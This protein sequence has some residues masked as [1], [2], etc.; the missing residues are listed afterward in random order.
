[1]EEGI[2]KTL[3]TI[4]EL[5]KLR[6]EGLISQDIF[7]EKEKTEK[8]KLRI[9]CVFWFGRYYGYAISEVIDLDPEYI[10]SLQEKSTDKHLLKLIQTIISNK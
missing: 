7:L 9:N 10:K 4:Y 5:R 8:W 1:M 3:E 6:N 2:Q